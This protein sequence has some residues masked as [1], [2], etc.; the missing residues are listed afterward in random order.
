MYIRDW[1]YEGFK[2]I[3][4]IPQIDTTHQQ[5]YFLTYESWASKLVTNGR[6]GDRLEMKEAT[7]T[8]LIDVISI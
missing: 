7:S 5:Y 2:F 1:A 4:S 6:R 3:K 8:H